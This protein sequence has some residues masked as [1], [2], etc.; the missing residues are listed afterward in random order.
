MEERLAYMA[1]RIEAVLS[2]HHVASRVTGGTVT[3]R[4]IRFRVLPAA[5]K[6][7]SGIEGLS[8]ELAMALGAPNCRV[9]RRGAAVEVEVS[10]DDP[11]PVQLLPLYRQL[12]G[13]GAGTIPPATAIL[14][15]AEDGAPL[16]I[17]LPSPHVAH[18]LVAGTEGA[19]KTVLL[20]SIVLSLALA[21]PAPSPLTGDGGMALVLVDLKGHAFDS[22]EGPSTGSGRGLPHL[23][24]PVIRRMDEAVEALQSLVRLMDRRTQVA[25]PGSKPC[26]DGGP[27][28]IVAID[29][30]AGLLAAANGMVSQALIHLT[31]RGR[32]AGIHVIAATRDIAMLESALSSS[33][34]AHFPVRLVGRVANATDARAAAGRLGTGVEQLLGRGDFLAV[35]EGRVIRFQAAYV[36]QEEISEVATHLA[37]EDAQPSPVALLQQANGRSGYPCPIFDEEEVK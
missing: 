23:A 14:G 4:W 20:Q 5:G 1:D 6:K 3:P 10:R 9:S 18:V 25:E 15:L 7:L 28:T 16:L 32:E 22:F 12:D 8:E 2:L 17:R 11:L 19:G 35:A 31:Q 26:L 33:A 24:R 29:E 27:C 34:K 37:Q 36:S 30:L 21:N 13:E